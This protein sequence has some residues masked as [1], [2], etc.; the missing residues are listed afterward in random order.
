MDTIAFQIF[1]SGDP[2]ALKRAKS[3]VVVGP[4]G[5][6]IGGQ[7]FPKAGWRDFPVAVLAA[8]TQKC[9]RLDAVGDSALLVFFEGPPRLRVE[10]LEDDLVKITAI[11][12]GVDG[13]TCVTSKIQ[14]WNELARVGHVVLSQCP[15][16]GWPSPDWNQ[17]WQNLDKHKHPVSLN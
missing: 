9:L 8:W 16:L 11:E 3:Q 10:Q 1:V 2:S 6:S 5:G 12:D 7:A 14:L 4:L 13:A 17:L 15:T